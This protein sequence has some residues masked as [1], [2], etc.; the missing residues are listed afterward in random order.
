MKLGLYADPH[1]S[2]SSSIIVGRRGEFTGRLDNLIQSFKWMN[3][4]F[5]ENSV[6]MTVCLGDLT[7]KSILTSE[8][9]TAMSKCEIESHHIIVG[10]HCRSDKDGKVNAVSNY[11][12]VYSEPTW[13]T[14]EVLLLPYNSSLYNLEEL[15]KEKHPK[16][17]LSHN[18]IRGYDFGA[19]HICTSGYDVTDIIKYCDLFINGHLHN[20]G[21][22]IDNKII[23]LGTISGINFASC[24]GQW[25]PSV[26][27]VDTDTMELTL[28]ENPVA[29]KFIKKEIKTVPKIKEFLDSLTGDNYVIQL[30][31]P[32]KIA[33]KARKFLDQSTKVEAS[34]ILT[35][36]EEVN[37]TELKKI[38]ESDSSTIYDKLKKYIS[39]KKPSYDINRLNNIIDEISK[40]EVPN[41]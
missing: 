37:K 32:D 24:G 3:N 10:N 35:I 17:I 8:E 23:N 28:Y 30:K 16:V 13:L 36:K 25:N 15:C 34:R 2:Q 5:R 20:G 14:S 27:I 22:L 29:Y 39:E 6:D 11:P 40:K 4:L 18:D 38:I 9:I 21:W 41:E 12:H 26:A 33:D 31:V 19:G 1:F 7:D